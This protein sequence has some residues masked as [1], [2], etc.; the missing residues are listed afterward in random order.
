MTGMRV[1]DFAKTHS[2][3]TSKILTVLENELGIAGKSTTSFLEDD[4]IAQLERHFKPTA[5]ISVA[6]HGR[7][8]ITVIRGRSGA[9]PHRTAISPASP[10]AKETPPAS[11]GV[12]IHVEEPLTSESGDAASKRPRDIDTKAHDLLRMKAQRHTG[13]VRKP[14]TSAEQLELEAKHPAAAGE[15]EPG[16]T[17]ESLPSAGPEKPPEPEQAA[18]PPSP[19]AQQVKPKPGTIAGRGQTETR[20]DKGLPHRGGKPEDQ[21][22]PGGKPQSPG[23]AAKPGAKPAAKSEPGAAATAAKKPPP[24]PGPLGRKEAVESR[25]ERRDNDEEKHGLNKLRRGSASKQQAK[26]KAYRRTKRERHEQQVQA[27]HAEQER[28]STTLKV[29][30]GTTV[31]DI[32]AGLHVTPA[33]LIA[34]LMELGVLV[35]I[36]QRLGSEVIEIIAEEFGFEIEKTSLIDDAIFGQF[37]TAEE[38]RPEDLAPRPPVVTVMGHVD[39]GKT[40]LLDFIRKSDVV[41]GEAGGITQHIGAYDVQLPKGRIA[42][43][44]TPGH[45]AFTAM[46]ARGAMVTD[47]VVLVVSATEGVMP[48]TVEAINHAKAANVPILVALNKIDLPT[49]DVERVKGQLNEHGLMPEEWGGKTQVVPVSALTGEGVEDLL[50]RLLLE[51]E[52][53]ELKANPKKRARGT[54]VESKLDPGRGPVATILVQDGTLRLGDSLVIGVFSGKARAML[55]DQ[56]HQITEAGPS[57]P[58]E[59]VGLSAVPE[60]GDTVVAVTDDKAA[61]QISAK[62]Q[63]IKRL[64]EIKRSK[65]ISLATLFAQ[66][67]EGKVKELNVIVKGDVQGSAGAVTEALQ[68]IASEAVKLRILHSGVGLISES[69]VMLAAASDGIIIGFNVGC[70]TGAAE[71]ANQENVDVRTYKIIYEIVD[72]ITKAMMGML[73]VRMEA[74]TIG[75]AEVRQVFPSTKYGTVA[76]C[77]VTRGKLTAK[78]RMRVM[79]DGVK[80]HEGKAASLR[81]FKDDVREVGEGLECGLCMIDFPGVQTGDIVECYEM[82]EAQRV[83]I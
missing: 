1:S 78:G 13:I 4:L 12:V 51:S 71:L 7:G 17:V 38:S 28:Q 18:H 62:M 70:A 31:A 45:A 49:A 5:R 22:K 25:K 77:V 54:V 64:R 82:R 47:V 60:A 32:S 40:K 27:A 10:V 43:I 83:L 26:K 44:D 33:E 80:L 11:V 3:E 46:R 73:E 57:T 39:H 16:S 67:Q 6:P 52:I 81:R 65:H 59:V 30:E 35:T 53:L 36:N 58:I 9:T 24:P 29:H 20:R 69:D 68:G 14:A 76:G 42:F 34:K 23:A 61:R 56:G 66:V 41:A 21:R 72:D 63:Q 55:N 2:V 15:S 48:Q 50:D 75:S 74:I 37:N 79:R 8:S 19:P